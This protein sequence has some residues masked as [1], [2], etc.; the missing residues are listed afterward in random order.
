VKT[1]LNLQQWFKFIIKWA[2][3]LTFIYQYVFTSRR[4]GDIYIHNRGWTP[5]HFGT[6]YLGGRVLDGT[7]YAN[8]RYAIRTILFYR[9]QISIIT[10]K[11]R[12]FRQETQRKWHIKT[13]NSKIFS[14]SLRSHL[15]FPH[16]SIYKTKHGL[17][18]YKLTIPSK[19]KTI[20]FAKMIVLWHA[21]IFIF[22]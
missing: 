6:Q 18:R 21:K 3:L 8:G 17:R 11:R 13:T 19:R 14:R 22:L 9:T 2:R 1:C 12:K 7:Q 4:P 15:L 20:M 16:F 10:L 5:P